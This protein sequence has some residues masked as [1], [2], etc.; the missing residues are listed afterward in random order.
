MRK[1]KHDIIHEYQ[2]E[3]YEDFGEWLE[4]IYDDQKIR[5][6]MKKQL[7][8]LFLNNKTLLLSKDSYM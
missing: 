8:L 4:S 1:N 5:K 6:P 2:H 3:D 7:L